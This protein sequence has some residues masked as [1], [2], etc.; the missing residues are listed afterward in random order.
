MQIN[1]KTIGEA[2]ERVIKLIL[3]EGEDLLVEPKPDGKRELTIEYPPDDPIM[4]RV[5]E[6]FT[7]PRISQVNPQGRLFM[8][9]YAR[10]FLVV[11]DTGHTYTYP[12]RLFDYPDFTGGTDDAWYFGG[13][14]DGSGRDQIQASIIDRLAKQPNSRRAVAITWFPLFDIE[15]HEPPCVDIVQVFIR[16]NQVHLVSYIR[17]NDMLEAWACDVWGLANLLMYVVNGINTKAG[18]AYEVGSITTISA[19][20]HIYWKRDQSDLDDFRRILGV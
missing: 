9:E 18:T 16:S 7:E 19:S 10:K 6:P 8:E 1:A 2:H 3:L 15:S 17:S 11:E 5:E 14:G 13:D 12:N 4:I 20:A